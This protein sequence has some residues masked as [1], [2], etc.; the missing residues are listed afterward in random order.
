[1]NVDYSHVVAFPFR[2]LRLTGDV[3]IWGANRRFKWPSTARALRG[4]TTAEQWLLPLLE[5]F[6]QKLHACNSEA[7]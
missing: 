1:M 2:V 4:K 3:V 7:V 5:F 6:G